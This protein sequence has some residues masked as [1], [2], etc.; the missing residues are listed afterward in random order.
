[1]DKVAVIAVHGVA[2]QAAGDTAR[3]VADLLVASSDVEL[4]Y[5]SR[6]QESLSLAVAPLH[7]YVQ[8]PHRRGVTPAAADRPLSKSIAQSFSSDF[9]LTARSAARPA[10]QAAAAAMPRDR[11][12]DLTDYLLG[13]QLDNHGA[14]EVY[15]TVR[16]DL[17]RET[18][19]K[20]SS[21]HVYEMYWA[22]LSRLSGAVP[23][24]VAEFATLIFRLSRLGRDTVDEACGALGASQGRARRWKLL[25]GLQML[26]DWLYVN[27]LSQL[28]AQLLAFGAFL[29]VLGW[30]LVAP[31][32][33]RDLT[34][35]QAT[36]DANACRVLAA[37]LL[38]FG[39]LLLVYRR[40][41][42][43]RT[44]VL[45]AVLFG[46]GAA[47]LVFPGYG[48][49]VAC[50]VL[51]AVMTLAYD[52]MLRVADERFPLTRL[53][54]LVIW[55]LIG[56]TVAWV[57]WDE[58]AGPVGFDGWRRVALY[59]VELTLLWIER[60]WFVL[61]VLLVLWL[62]VGVCTQVGGG[63]EAQAS[64]ATGRLGLG[65]SLCSFV[66]LT[67]GLWAVLSTVLDLSVARLSYTPRLSMLA[68]QAVAAMP[69]SAASASTAQDFLRQRYEASTEAFAPTAIL[70]LALIG[71]VAATLTPSVLA[72]LQVFKEPGPKASNL[73]A[74]SGPV[75]RA[76]PPAGSESRA[77]QLGRWL[78]GGYRRM[79]GFLLS[80]SA[81]GVALVVAV[82]CVVV[83][84][85]GVQDL[86]SRYRPLIAQV[87]HTWLEPLVI[88]AATLGAAFS[89]LGGWLSK[90][91]PA[92]RAPLDAGLDVDNYFRE[93]PRT[94]IPR[95]RIFAR[96]VALLEHMAT[97]GYTR[98]V[99]VAHSQGCVISAEAL[100]W[101][102]YGKEHGLHASPARQVLNAQ[103]DLDL[104]LLTLG[105]PLRQLYAARFPTLYR[106]V[107]ARKPVGYGPQARD[108]GVRQWINAYT[109]GDYV[110]RWLWTRD[111][112]SGDTLGHPLAD[113]ISPAVMGRS[114]A[115]DDFPRMPPQ[116]REL[117]H[118][119]EL[120]ACLGVGAHTHYLEMN[121]RRV[122]WLIS[123]LIGSAGPSGGPAER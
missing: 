108:I 3:A 4:R 20:S 57:M 64:V 79:D 63:V 2:D 119:A 120:E 10:P 85:A 19:E 75:R 50:A 123:Y 60:L 16:I 45:P 18:A 55:A 8:A 7:P 72:E 22:D 41:A 116:T 52:A 5:S 81:L 65:I 100:R 87:S 40:R 6:H 27:V 21:V 103:L 101:L 46:A 88:S 76:V 70:L 80:M 114:A 37:G 77:F 14:Q 35:L 9:Q 42:P 115:Y 62:C 26:L 49:S 34:R 38:V 31:V 39:V 86:L 90:Y 99:I 107:L 15:D 51:L 54:G 104:R 47:M 98:I 92:I 33:G 73:K 78:T 97:Q 59:G 44:R 12:L 94:Q 48:P 69:A 111:D 36:F 29:V 23:R 106:W 74:A 121:Q 110:G 112:A 1:M 118:H 17:V 53:S 122:A 24:I 61:A 66:T 71:Y 13:K 67:M 117:D 28:F 25:A 95:A 30:M 82:A 84:G 102:S 11:G 68:V 83:G 89:I 91:V 96:Y 105:C 113:T 58:V 56:A 43:G 109:S 32:P 93:F